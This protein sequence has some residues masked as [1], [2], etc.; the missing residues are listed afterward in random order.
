MEESSIFNSIFNNNKSEIDIEYN[1]NKIT[2]ESNVFY[3]DTIFE[4][5]LER[6][7]LRQLPFS[8]QN[9]F[10][11][12]KKVLTKVHTFLNLKNKAII[13]ENK[14]F[15]H[16]QIKNDYFQN[17]FYNFLIPVVIDKKKVYKDIGS[18]DT[19]E[20][21]IDSKQYLCD[22]CDK[23]SIYFTDEKKEQEHR[24]QLYTDYLNGNLNYIDYERQLFMINKPYANV[25]DVG[26]GICPKEN[27]TAL[28]FYDI[29]T[30]QWSA[31]QC[32][33]NYC[34]SLEDYNQELK[35][36]T[37]KQQC[38]IP[39][40]DTNIVGFLKLKDIN[41]SLISEINKSSLFNCS[42]FGF[43]S[44]IDKITEGKTTIITCK[45]HNL[46]KENLII[47]KDSELPINGVYNIDITDKDT[48]QINFDS[49][50][51]KIEGELGS[52]YSKKGLDMNV[53][54]IGKDLKINKEDKNKN[55]LYLFNKDK[56][57]KEDY[58]KLLDKIVPDVCEE[59]INKINKINNVDDLL[60][61]INYYI[62]NKFNFVEEDYNK[63]LEAQNKKFKE[64]LEKNINKNKYENKNK[65][66]KE[67]FLLS[68]KIFYDKEIIEAYGN[69]PLKDNKNDNNISRLNWIGSTLDN[70]DFYYAFL[71]KY[72]FENNKFNDEKNLFE[73][74]IS[75]YKQKLKNIN[76]DL[77]KD[78][79]SKDYFE[80]EKYT[81]T[82]SS[83]E[84]LDNDDNI[85]EGSVA[86]IKSDDE[87]NGKIYIYKNR[88][89]LTKKK[90][91]TIDEI[92]MFKNK[93]IDDIKLKDLTC[94]FIENKCINRKYKRNK[95]KKEYYTKILEQYSELL[96]DFTTNSLKDEILNNYN[97]TK[98][99]ILLLKFKKNIKKEEKI[100][101][102]VKNK[103]LKFKQILLMNKILKIPNSITLK[104]YIFKVI[105]LDGITID[106]YIYSKK[107]K[108][109]MICSHWKYYKRVE[110]ASS[111]SRKIELTKNLIAKFGVNDDKKSSSNLSCRICGVPLDIINYDELE[112]FDAYGHIIR[113]RAVMTSDEKNPNILVINP[114]KQVTFFMPEQ[115]DCSNPKFR[116]FLIDKGIQIGNLKISIDICNIAKSIADKIGLHIR[117]DHLIKI[118]LES[119]NL[120]K[121]I[122]TLKQFKIIK[123]KGMLNLGQEDRVKLL[124]KTNYFID[125][126][127]YYYKLEKYS[128]ISVF[129][130]ILLQ[131]S[132]PKYTLKK[133][134]SAC[135]LSSFEESKGLTYFS[136]IIKEL[137]VLNY[138][139]KK[140]DG[141]EKTKIIKEVEILKHMNDVYEK[142]KI[143]PFIVE[144]FS[145]RRDY[146][147]K[148][149]EHN[150]KKIIN[151]DYKGKQKDNPHHLPSNFKQYILGLKG[152]IEVKEDFNRYYRRSVY[153][154]R[155]FIRNY[156]IYNK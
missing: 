36:I 97:H 73:K 26:Y 96:E 152:K 44:K 109:P 153:L 77:E 122:L 47:I 135:T 79:K 61:I 7:L 32:L 111:S 28:R 67:I 38:I 138:S 42:N 58:L 3:D 112:Q 25:E 50:D 117:S 118:I 128:I 110:D 127:T 83:L 15:K 150:N 154:T 69:Y 62:R 19:L 98:N 54:N 12:Q 120:I 114:A 1:Y 90:D 123:I 84:D 108:L 93:D 139:I 18:D 48:I 4:A 87:H 20:E 16:S 57:L 40:E 106:D 68:D 6:A 156:E 29:N 85:K 65:I 49:S 64:L 23:D 35:K 151:K 27:F 8:K 113:T 142:I 53:I 71:V 143:L 100:E 55:N 141:T 107:F 60:K 130:L 74:K 92:C 102:P 59:I 116:D 66:E 22:I 133:P 140:K 13:N 41:E 17:K 125:Q 129:I 45:N 119:T 72:L 144:A 80:C 136:C 37:I 115:I 24:N 21:K 134:K 95:D 14:C 104:Y 76:E 101:T 34:I 146:D 145:K 155:E 2:E 86:I 91:T 89:I 149:K 137:G 75:E 82:F 11:F 30:I 52:I 10:L 103:Q 131:T 132:I 121:K 105:E 33:K 51:L 56:I 99:K 148:S 88:W 43:I 31:K 46:E 70:G 39:S 78:N 81:Y 63:I 147:Y 94:E 126:Y 124:E 9:N 5:S